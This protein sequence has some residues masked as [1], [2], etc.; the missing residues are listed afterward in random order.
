MQPGNKHISITF[1]VLHAFLDIGFILRE[2]FIKHQGKMK[3]TREKWKRGKKGYDFLLLAH[4]YLFVFRK[5]LG[6][7][8]ITSYKNNVKW[9]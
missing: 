3:S 9:W 2:D 4:E 7:G 5:L 8:N 6:F 1:R